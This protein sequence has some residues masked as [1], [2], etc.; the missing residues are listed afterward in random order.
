[1]LW[2]ALVGDRVARDHVLPTVGRPLRAVRGGWESGDR[3]GGADVGDVAWRSPSC[4]VAGGGQVGGEGWVGRR[5]GNARV[6]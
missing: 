1:M 5:R 6:Q 4:H 3:D 2:R